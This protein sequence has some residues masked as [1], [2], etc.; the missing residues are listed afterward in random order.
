[1]TASLWCGCGVWKV[2]VSPGS[3]GGEGAGRML[4]GVENRV[5][6]WLAV[7]IALVGGEIALGGRTFRENR[8]CVCGGGTLPAGGQKRGR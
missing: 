1:M 6:G 4:G 8:V 5:V 3:R 2:K 7:E